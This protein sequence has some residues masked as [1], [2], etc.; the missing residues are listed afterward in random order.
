MGIE[1]FPLYTLSFHIDTCN[2]D[3]QTFNIFYDKIL[4][5]P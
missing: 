5:Q 1:I 4:S 2:D 3:T